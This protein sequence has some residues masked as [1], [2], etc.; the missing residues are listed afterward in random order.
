MIAEFMFVA[1]TCINM[2]CA[3]MVSHQPIPKAQCEIFKKQF[4]ELPFKPE[5]TLAAA[6]CVELPR[7]VKH[8]KNLL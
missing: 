7:K 1:V 8:E 5:V 6:Q 2:D 3:F 4:S